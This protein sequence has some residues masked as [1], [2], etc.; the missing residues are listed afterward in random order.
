M[1]RR[2]NNFTSDI[3]DSE[4]YTHLLYQVL[5]S[6]SPTFYAQLLWAQIPKAQKYNLLASLGLKDELKMIFF[7][8]FQIAPLELGVS[9]EALMESD[10]TNRA[11]I[12]LQQV[13]GLY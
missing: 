5:G 2:V 4:A 3:S 13:R 6:I 9:K 10:L 7:F 1:Q 12:M 8:N 11:E